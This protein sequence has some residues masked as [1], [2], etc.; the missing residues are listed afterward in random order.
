MRVRLV[1]PFAHALRELTLS[2]DPATGCLRRY[3]S[4]DALKRSVRL[5]DVVANCLEQEPENPGGNR[6]RFLCFRHDDHHPSLWVNV[7]EQRWGCHAGC[8]GG[9][10]DVVDFVREIHCLTYKEAIDWLR[11][12]AM[13]H[14]EGS[15]TRGRI[16]IRLRKGGRS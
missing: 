11:L 2:V 12:W 10:G 3:Q 4:L 1:P 14:S 13:Y 9:S 8:F 5:E 16:R 7:E 15:A 6:L